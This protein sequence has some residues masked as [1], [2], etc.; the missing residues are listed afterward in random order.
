MATDVPIGL[1][2]HDGGL[3][4]WT[5]MLGDSLLFPQFSYK[6]NTSLKIKVYGAGPMA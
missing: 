1:G 6:P 2:V 5:E 3:W 4:G